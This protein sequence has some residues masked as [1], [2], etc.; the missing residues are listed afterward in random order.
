MAPGDVVVVHKEVDGWYSATR[1]ADGTQGL[2][3]SSYVEVDH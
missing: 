3:P 1:V 2:V